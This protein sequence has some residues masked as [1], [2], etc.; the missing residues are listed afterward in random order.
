[1]CP[2]GGKSDNKVY[3]GDRLFEAGE[4]DHIFD[5]DMGDNVSRKLPFD[6][7]S[8]PLEAAEKFLIRE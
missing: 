8:N 5:V 7:G 2:P 6:N 1:V 4:Y 3:E